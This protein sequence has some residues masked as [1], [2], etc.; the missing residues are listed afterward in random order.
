[1]AVIIPPWLETKPSDFANAAESGLRIGAQREATDASAQ[2]AAARIQAQVDESAQQQEIERQRGEAQDQIAQARNNILTQAA[3]RKFQAQQAYQADI[4]S[5][6]DPVK[7]L[8]THGPQM[9]ESLAGL[10]TL[11]L[12]QFKQKQAMVPPSIIKDESGRAIGVYHAGQFSR[13]NNP[14]RSAATARA[15]IDPSDK[16]YVDALTKQL[17][18]GDDTGNAPIMSKIEGILY[19]DRKAV[20]PVLTYDPKTKSFISSANQQDQVEF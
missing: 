2:E 16:A 9:G 1:M 12:D 7:A 19:P 3:A 4:A 17:T 6:M 10:G 11:G 15:M 14:P 5:G 13:V 18:P 20:A 8:M